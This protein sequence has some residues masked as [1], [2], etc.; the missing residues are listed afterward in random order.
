MSSDFPTTPGA[1]DESYNG[2]EYDAFVSK[3]D[4]SLSSLLASTFIGGSGKESGTSIVIDSTG[5]VYMTGE[6]NSS[7]FPA[8]FGA[9]DESYNSPG[10]NVFVSRLDSN[11]TT[12]RSSTFIG[13]SGWNNWAT[14]ECM[15]I[16]WTGNVYITGGAGHSGGTAYPTT[17]GS[18]DPT[19]N[20]D[21]DVFISKLDPDLTSL[22][23]STF[24]GGA[25]R[26]VGRSMVF[27][28]A[29]NVYVYGNTGASGYPT[30]PGAYDRSH[31]GNNDTFVS[32]LDSNLSFL[33]ASTF[34]GGSGNDSNGP[35]AFDGAGNI[36]VTG[37]TSSSNF[38]TTPGA[39]DE[40][41]NGGEY[42][43]FVSKLDSSLSSLLASTFIGGNDYDRIGESGMAINAYG[44][45]YVAGGTPSSDY[46]T[47]FGAY[48]ENYNGGGWDVFVSKLDSELATSPAKQ[49]TDLVADVIDLN[50]Q[51]GLENSL[52]A[53][54][55]SV[56]SAL[57]DINENN[58]VAAINSLGAFINA[59][60]AQRGN[61]ISDSDA[62]TLIVAAQ[63]IIDLLLAGG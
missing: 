29:G 32:K 36:Y 50:L 48:N 4:S 31:D 14:G 39:Y 59:V 26:E 33:L 22:L 1:Y 42:D 13:G 9:Y 17:A 58:D 40:S 6:T 61:K 7:D 41:Y 38:P 2:G 53:K 24:I 11:L 28:G 5:T 54:L 44:Y 10:P 43:A 63:Q 62:D 55:D 46:P 60:E 47:T 25:G 49:V 45:I 30:T 3:L 27:D 21:I 19:H 16:D 15:L 52:D 57:D 37:Y 20:G 35:I 34:I 51:Q 56:L 18:Y 8:T 23:A 12:L